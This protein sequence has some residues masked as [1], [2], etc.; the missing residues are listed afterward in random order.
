M[1]RRLSAD[2]RSLVSAL[3][4]LSQLGLSP[5]D[6]GN[7]SVR[8]DGGILISPTGIAGADTRPDQL[9]FMTLAGDVPAGQLRPSSEAP[10]HLALYRDR[11]DANAVVHCHSAFATA[12]SA[13]RRDIPA[14]HYMV[15]V[16][17]GDSIRCAEYAI[18]GSDELS[19]NAVTAM[20][21][22]NACLLAN[23][24][25]ITIGK[26]LDAALALAAEV[27]QLAS[28]YS[29]CLNIGSVSILDAAEM[30]AVLDKFQGYGQQAE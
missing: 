19:A 21:G 16:A 17:G 18:F 11:S 15:A 13:T 3:Q 7:I 9:V 30:K 14:W 1:K 2:R 12:L 28:G 27:E 29:R 10:M 26:N 4:R 8:V 22:R 6:S 20:S 25:Q 5:G 24:G 23:H